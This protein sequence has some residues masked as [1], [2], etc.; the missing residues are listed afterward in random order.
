AFGPD[1]VVNAA[2]VTAVDAAE[3]DPGPAW[4][5]NRDGARAVALACA[6]AGIP[7]VHLSTDY[8]FDGGVPGSR[9]PYRPFDPVRPLSVYGASK[10]AGEVAVRET[11]RSHAIVR[12]SWV[13]SAGG[14]NFLTTMLRLAGE[15]PELRVVDDQIGCPTSAADVAAAI[16]VLARHLLDGTCSA[17]GTHHF[18]NA[19]PASWFDFAQ[20]IFGRAARM[21]VAVPRL[22]PIPTSAYPTPAR[23]PLWSVLDT[24][25]LQ[26]AIGHVPRPWTEAL[27]DVMAELAVPAGA[28]A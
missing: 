8:V 7:L 11:H 9:H 16:V 3:T 17:L 4:A 19:G 21:G 10:A 6:A 25:G 20:S 2:A 28:A 24:A 27:A 14:R 5:V 18:C 26:A 22:V 13:F 12:T 23:R 1:L 15:R